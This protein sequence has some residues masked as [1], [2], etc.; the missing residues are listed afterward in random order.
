MSEFKKA[1]GLVA[2]KIEF[3]KFSIIYH[4]KANVDISSPQH[5]SSPF[6]VIN[7]DLILKPT[8]V[9][10]DCMKVVYTPSNCVPEFYQ[11]IYDK[12]IRNV[13]EYEIERRHIYEVGE[14]VGYI[15]L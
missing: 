6:D 13:S 7:K 9:S 1:I 3:T 14:I 8:L 10:K 2:E 5:V 11:A 4:V 15:L 12:T